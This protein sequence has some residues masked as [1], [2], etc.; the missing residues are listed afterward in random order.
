MYMS[1]VYALLYMLMSALPVIYGEMRGMSPFVSTLPFFS[2]FIGIL[3]GGAFIILD[4]KRYARKLKELGAE[5]DG[6]PEQRF[7]PMGLGAIL[8]PIGLFWFAFTGPAQTSSPWPSIIALAFCMCGMVLIFECSI[9]FMIDMYR[10]FAN[11]AIA[12]NTIVRSI[13]GGAFPLFTTGMIHNLG[14]ESTWAMFLL[15][16]LSLIMA[17]IPFIFYRYGARLRAMSKFSLEL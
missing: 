17:P 6:L 9:V 3:F 11:S 5:E 12:A 10:S 8:L 2:V 15:A 1:F 16:C 13:L 7:V 4:M 14:W